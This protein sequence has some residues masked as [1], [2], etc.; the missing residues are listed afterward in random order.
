MDF[1][2]QQKIT[3]HLSP[4]ERVLWTGRPKTGLALR[5]GD[6]SA[7]PFTIVWFGFL[8]FFLWKAFEAG[9]PVQAVVTLII[10][11]LVGFYVLLGRFFL[12]ARNRARTYYGLT[13]QRVMIASGRTGQELTSVSLNTLQDISITTKGDGTG[14]ITLGSES[15]KPSWFA[16]TS[17]PGAKKKGPPSL[18]MIPHARD[19]Y[20]QILKAQRELRS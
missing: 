20:N 11:M 8:L 9:A 18:F 1:D 7:I 17:W 4:G 16:A 14:T 10:F 19:V 15:G 2:A 13:E 5:P 12:D 6:I 3:P